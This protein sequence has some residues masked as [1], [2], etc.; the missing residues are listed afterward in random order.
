MNSP[1]LIGHPWTPLV[2]TGGNRGRDSKRSSMQGRPKNSERE[3]ARPGVWDELTRGLAASTSLTPDR[4]PG[5]A[6]QTQRMQDIC[7]CF[8]HQDRRA[9]WLEH[10]L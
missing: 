4:A 2:G 10:R 9:E 6:P 3:G 5:A 8:Q 1:L 7:L